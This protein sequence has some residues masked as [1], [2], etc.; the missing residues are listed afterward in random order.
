VKWIKRYTGT[1]ED[2]LFFQVGL[3]LVKNSIE[4]KGL[5]ISVI[6]EP[7]CSMTAGK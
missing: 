7:F 5:I 2:W 6:R 3:F 1:Y 4:K